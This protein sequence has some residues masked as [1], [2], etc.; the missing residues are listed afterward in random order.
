MKIT[1]YSNGKSELLLIQDS[2]GR[3]IK[4]D[5]YTIGNCLIDILFGKNI[6]FDNEMINVNASTRNKLITLLEKC[7]DYLNNDI[8]KQIEKELSFIFDNSYVYQNKL[9]ENKIEKIYFMD[10]IESL[11]SLLITQ[12]YIRKIMY[13]RCA[14]CNNLF[15]TRYSNARYCKRR[16]TLS[17]K[18]CGYA[19]RLKGNLKT[20]SYYAH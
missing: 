14:Y 16:A 1:Y 8:Q 5:R 7:N 11:I 19:A 18:G 13:K 3:T 10:D 4:K 20:N 15:A 17:G 2:D 12:I 6:I 9:I